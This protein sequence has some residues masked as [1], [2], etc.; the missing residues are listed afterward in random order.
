M[1]LW[2]I[3]HNSTKSNPTQLS[4]IVIDNDGIVNN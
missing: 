2:A 1:E 3:K 4:L